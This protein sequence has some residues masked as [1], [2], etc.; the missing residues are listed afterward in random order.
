ME[1]GG[2][3]CFMMDKINA[4]RFVVIPCTCA[5]WPCACMMM[6][7]ACSILHRLAS[8]PLC[9]STSGIAADALLQPIQGA[10]RMHAQARSFMKHT[11]R[12]YS[13]RL[14]WQTQPT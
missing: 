12:T 5:A 11:K 6:R 10:M 3:S 4:M 13:Y 1:Q 2:E 14:A 7:N 9:N 8:P